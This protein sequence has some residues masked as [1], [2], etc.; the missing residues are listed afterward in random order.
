M[1]VDCSWFVVSGRVKVAASRIHWAA[2]FGCGA[3]RDAAGR[4]GERGAAALDDAVESLHRLRPRVMRQHARAPG[5]GEA[6]ALGLVGHQHASTA[7]AHFGTRLGD[8]QML[9]G[10]GIDAA[11][12]DIAR[13]HRHAHRHR[14]QDLVL[15]A[16]RDVE[17]RHHQPRSAARRGARPAP[18][19]SLSTP[20]SSPSRARRA[21]DPRRRSAA[22]AAGLRSRMMRPGGS[23]EVEHAL[24]VR[25]VIHPAR[26]TKPCRARRL[27]DRSE[28]LAVDAVREPVGRRAGCHSLSSVCHSARVVAVQ[29]SNCRARRRSSA[30]QL[31]PSEPIPCAQRERLEVARTRATSASPCRRNR[32][33]SAS[34]RAATRTGATD[35]QCTKMRSNFSVDK[36]AIDRAR[37]RGRVK[38]AERRRRGR[39][40]AAPPSAAPAPRS[41]TSPISNRLQ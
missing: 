23:A 20:G 9:A 12:G 38:V 36:Q 18:S 7:S 6:G 31:A 21:K 13:D 27:A 1:C 29:R 16:A 37:E 28:V 25:V 24:L 2:Q 5:F 10:D 15:R 11:G 30:T 26:R 17:R 8:E 22:S 32:G 33:S 4:L 14:F 40:A 34:P 19:P 3:R 35:E 39:A 41:S